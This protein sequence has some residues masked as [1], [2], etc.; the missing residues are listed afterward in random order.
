MAHGI[1]F[2]ERAAQRAAIGAALLLGCA[3]G[4]TGCAP[5]TDGGG[6]A[7]PTP[8]SQN[9][10]STAAGADSASSAGADGTGSSESG[11]GASASGEGKPRAASDATGEDSWPER[12]PEG[13]TPKH[14]EIP[15]SFPSGDFVIGSGAVIDDVGERASGGWFLVLRAADAR[16]A[17]TRWQ[18]VISSNGFSVADSAATPEGG[19]SATLSNQ[20][21]VVDALTLPQS[22]GSVLLSYDIERTG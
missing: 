20:R 19:V 17:D 6:D 9:G 7:T 13:G 16:E 22:D 1:R 5:E 14:T 8:T 2:G 18:T 11:A 4:A 3:L 15:S 10:S 12:E 21:L